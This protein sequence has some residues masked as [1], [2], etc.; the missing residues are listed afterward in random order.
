MMGPEPSA[1]IALLDVGLLGLDPAGRLGVAVATIGALPAGGI[2]DA[3]GS[4]RRAIE[5]E[6]RWATVWLEDGTWR[7]LS[8]IDGEKLATRRVEAFVPLLVIDL[9]AL[10]PKIETI[11][12][13]GFGACIVIDAFGELDR[14]HSRVPEPVSLAATIRA[15]SAGR[16]L[17]GEH[18]LG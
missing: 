6:R 7:Y 3:I 5:A 9:G 15:F 11:D 10:T 14:A 18:G 17:V 12:A 1:C 4:A 8:A 2:A 16:A 13:T